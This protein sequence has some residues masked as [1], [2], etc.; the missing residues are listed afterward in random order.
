[1]MNLPSVPLFNI[2]SAQAVRQPEK[3]VNKGSHTRDVRYSQ[4][5]DIFSLAEAKKPFGSSFSFSFEQGF[6]LQILRC[7]SRVKFA[8]FNITILY[9]V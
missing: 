2:A 6:D 3:S 1:M 8:L 9:F 7:R 5:L 4:G